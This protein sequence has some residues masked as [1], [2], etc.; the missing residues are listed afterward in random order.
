MTVRCWHQDPAQRPNIAEVA[1]CL[2][3]LS[4]S[5]LSMEADLLD[6]FEVCKTRGKDGQGEKAREFVNELDEVW[7]R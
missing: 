5:A 6:F 3:K 2:R 7:P 1:G 4:V